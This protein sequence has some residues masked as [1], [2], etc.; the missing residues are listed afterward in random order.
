MENEYNSYLTKYSGSSNAFTVYASTNYYFGLSAT[1]VAKDPSSSGSSGRTSLPVSKA[2]A[3]FHGAL[4]RFA[5]F[6]IRP[7]FCKDTLECEL[8][9]VDS[10]NKKNLQSDQWRMV[11]LDSELSNENHPY[12]K[13][14]TGNYH[15]LHDEPLAKGIN[16]RDAFI[17]FHK[18][19][20]S[21]NRMKLVVLGRDGLDE[22]QA[23][24][25]ELFSAVPNRNLPKS[26][27]NGI[28]VYGESNLGIEVFVKPVMQERQ[29][30][31]HFPYP[32]E[33]ELW[34]SKPG[35]YIAHLVGH[36]GPGSLLACLQARGWVN[37][38][39]AGPVPLGP[40]T[41]RFFCSLT[42]TEEGLKHNREIVKVFFQYVALLKDSSP[43]KWVVEEMARLS[44]IERQVPPEEP[45][46]YDHKRIER[47]YATTSAQRE[48]FQRVIL[49][50]QVR[51]NGHFTRIG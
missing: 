3:P 13:F 12:H 17:G 45:C 7:L 38:L 28:P 30:E 1:S 32:D 25:G 16:I 4:D 49:D 50:H 39:S 34:Q 18:E 24:V 35:K 23:W 47:F 9:A 36:E 2:S 33:V 37:N 43:Q 6:F 14:K 31:L 19:H 5:Q 40:G 42:L 48:D 22:L 15:T 8:R 11:Q 21:A 29:L 41:G 46:Q 44:E 10:E 27:W 20:Y 51:P 26:Q